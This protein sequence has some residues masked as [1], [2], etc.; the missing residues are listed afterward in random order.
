MNRIIKTVLLNLI[1]VLII[2]GCGMSDYAVDNKAPEINGFVP[3]KAGNYDSSDKAVVVD[4]NTSECKITL[5]TTFI[6]RKY[7]LY[8]DGATV[9][10]DKYGTGMSIMQLKCGDLVD[11]NFL[12]AWKRLD[13]LK[14][15]EN[16]FTFKNTKDYQFSFDGKH[17]MIAGQQYT[18]DD[19]LAVVSSD[20]TLELMDINPVDELSFTGSDHIIYS[21]VI[22]RSHGYLKLV[23]DSYF[24]GG[25]IEV[26]QRQIVKIEEDMLI[27]VPVGTYPVTVSNAGSSGQET[28]TIEQGKEYELDVSGWQA[29]AKYGDIVF[30]LN[31]SNAR[32]YIDGNVIDSKEPVNLE[33]GIH[34][35]IVVADGYQTISRYI[36][37]ASESAS[38]EVDMELKDRSVSSN[39]VTVEDIYDRRSDSVIGVSDNNTVSFNIINPPASNTDNDSKDTSKDSQSDNKADNTSNQNQQDDISDAVST[40]ASYKVYIDAPSDA[41]VYVDGAYIGI[42]PVSFNK[43][44]GTV[45]VI[46]RKSGYETRSYTLNLD[47]EKKDVNYSFS[48]LDKIQ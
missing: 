35:M 31:P 4:I 3:A 12:K 28:V 44:E 20:G 32:V 37:V 38:L 8:Y 24:V 33:Y 30:A 42:S 15:S 22:E 36:K 40:T 2:A 13:R 16:Q 48:E 6:G 21:I 29:E 34:Q 7:T 18:L 39:N 41:E 25:W 45:V 46:L 43:K 27:A 26:S 11:V 17:V 10:E 47:N 19:N 5:K 1:A 23:N 9:F 14:L